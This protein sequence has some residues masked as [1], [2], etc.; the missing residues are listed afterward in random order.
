MKLSFVI[1]AYNEEKNIGD[2]V[3]SMIDEIERSGRD[4]EII[5]VNNASTDSTKDVALKHKGVKVVDEN[6]KGI[7]WARKAGFEASTGDL[8]ANIDADNRLPKGWLN[9]VFAHFDKHGDLMALSG[10]LVYYDSSLYIRSM[11]KMFYVFGFAFDRLSKYTIGVSSLL[12]GG[13]FIL[14]RDALHKIGGYDTSIEFYAEDSNIG[15]RV[16]KIGKVIWTFK[17]PMNSSGRRLQKEGLI[18]M[19]IKYGLNYIWMA[20]AH[21][22]FSKKYKDIRT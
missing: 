11:T 20:F 5:V 2:C 3:L 15:K 16:S 10:P 12:Q 19:G 14:H 9:T 7:V 18:T 1:P 22:P 17:L 13:N 4:C 21:K 6:R 8:I